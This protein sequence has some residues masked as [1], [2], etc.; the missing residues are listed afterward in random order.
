MAEAPNQKTLGDVVEQLQ[1]LNAATEM[2]EETARYTQELRD[3]MQNEGANLDTN[4][5]TAIEDLI[6]VLKDGRLDD[7]EA[8]KEQMLRARVEARRDAERNDLLEK[9]SKFTGENVETLK[10]EF[11]NKSRGIIMGLI[12]RTAIRGVLLGFLSSVFFE[13]FRLIGKGLSAI[14]TK[15]GKLLGFPGFFKNLRLGIQTN[16]S[17]GFKAF[18]NIF[19]PKGNK[20]PGFLAK[21]GKELMTVMK[22]VFRIVRVSVSNVLKVLT[23]VTGFLA[24]RFGAL[25][26]LTKIK[27]NVPTQ[28]KFIGFFAKAL[29]T[30]FKPLNGLVKLFGTQQS[31]IVKSIDRAGKSAIAT[32]GFFSKLGTNL[33]TF[34]KTLKPIQTAFQFLG[35][36][37]NAFKGIGRVLGRFFGVFN[38][39]VGF[40]KGFKKY[41]D[42]SFV[43]KLF[44]GI[45]G[46]FKNLLLMGPIFILDGLKFILGKILGFFGFEKAAEFLSSFSFTKI[47]GDAFDAVTDSIIQFFAK[48]KDTISDIGFGGIIKN[49]GV[50]MLKIVKKIATFPQAIMAGGLGAIAAALPGG[51]TP[52]EGFKEGFNKVFSAGDSA[53]DSLKAKADGMNKDGQLINA[54]SEEGKALKDAAIAGPRISDEELARRGTV[55]YDIQ[56][57]AGDTVNVIT[58]ATKEA[59]STVNGVIANVYT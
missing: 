1:E 50:S 30:L 17:N 47:V 39:I 36:V 28:S 8:E 25:E 22:D 18:V 59:V 14:G 26:S 13:P 38:F 5:L 7:L 41:E 32:T 34:F 6:A 49:I 44:A 42:G 56:Q 35:R 19:K 40:F 43:T 45:M 55:M 29:D 52:M 27:F 58:T 57:K 54:K 33:F 2:A 46:G 12:I 21:S 11:G 51:K 23:A 48:I 31:Q 9:I 16:V 24:G 10:A 3:Y 20:P 53:L 37:G 15:I 4:Q